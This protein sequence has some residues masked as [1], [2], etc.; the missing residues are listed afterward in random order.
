MNAHRVQHHVYQGK[1]I[2]LR[3]AEI[4]MDKMHP[5]QNSQT[6]FEDMNLMQLLLCSN[7]ER[8]YFGFRGKTGAGIEYDRHKH[9]KVQWH[10]A[11]VSSG[12]WGLICKG[13]LNSK[14]CL[15]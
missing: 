13:C 8:E 15:M 7:S 9:T 2:A 14:V 3:L 6:A 10:Q 1:S 12:D 5:E 4:V 11:L